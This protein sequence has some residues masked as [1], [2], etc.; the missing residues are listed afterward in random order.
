MCE[1]LLKDIGWKDDSNAKAN[2]LLTIETGIN[3]TSIEIFRL[4]RLKLLQ[5]PVSY[6][7][8]AVWGF[9]DGGEID[10]EQHAINRLIRPLMQELNNI[11]QLER[12]NQRHALVVE[13]MVRGL[14]IMKIVYMI[15][16]YNNLK[17]S[18]KCPDGHVREYGSYR[19]EDVEPVGRA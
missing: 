13:Y 15:E 12:L 10:P 3:K 9:K 1:K 7:I 17:N 16:C 5:A 8:P 6:I 19:L 18:K 2:I 4:H 14:I 11:L